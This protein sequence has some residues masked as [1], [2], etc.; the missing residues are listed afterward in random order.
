MRGNRSISHLW[1]V[2]PDKSGSNRQKLNERRFR[3]RRTKR[4]NVTE[5]VSV[6]I[7]LKIVV[8]YFSM[9][10]HRNQFFQRCFGPE[11]FG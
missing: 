7:F 4:R 3:F 9:Q 11:K 6:D 2:L 5:N 8:N 1:N 10:N